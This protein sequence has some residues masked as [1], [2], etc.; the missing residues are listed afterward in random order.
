MMF[1]T[2]KYIHL[3]IFFIRFIKNAIIIFFR[4]LIKT[5][6]DEMCLIFFKNKTV[7]KQIDKL[8]FLNNR[9]NNNVFQSVLFEK[10]DE[11]IVLKF[12][13]FQKNYYINALK[14]TVHKTIFHD[15]KKAKKQHFVE[16][17]AAIKI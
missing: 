4:L 12:V 6:H 1:I 2:E 9:L 15:H 11:I 16:R 17:I 3:S 5:F 7:K 10:F 8:I 13:L 14:A